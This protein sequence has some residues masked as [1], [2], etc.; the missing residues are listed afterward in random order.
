MMAQVILGDT[1]C[2]QFFR[3]HPWTEQDSDISVPNGLCVTY[4]GREGQFY[5]GNCLFSYSMNRTN[6][7]FSKLSSNPDLLN[8][9]LCGPYN[10]KGFLCGECVEGFGPAVY[11]ESLKCA[12]CSELPRGYAIGLYAV[13]RLVPLT[14][15]FILIAVFHVNITSGPLLG[16]MIFC[17]FVVFVVREKHFIIDF[18]LS[19]NHKFVKFLILL[20]LTLCEVWNLNFFRPFIPPFC[21]S[22]YLSTVHIKM[23]ELL[24]VIYILAL[25]LITYI[26]IEMYSH[27]K[28][29][30]ILCKPFRVILN[31]SNIYKVGWDSVVHA[32]ATVI[33]LS[34]T[35][36]IYVLSSLFH[37]AFTFSYSTNG[38]CEFDHN[39]L[40]IDPMVTYDSIHRWIYVCI[41]LIP[42]ILVVFIPS[43]L[44][45]LYPTRIYRDASRLIS[46]RKR[47][48]IT[49]F[50]E[51]LNSCFKDG[52]NGTID[53][54]AL[55][56]LVLILVPFQA[57]INV[58][59]WKTLFNNSFNR[60]L[61]LA[62][63]CFAS[64]LFVSSTRPCK[65]LLGNLSLS[66]HLMMMG[67][68]SLT[69]FL[70]EYDLSSSTQTLELVIFTI[71]II[72]HFLVLC[73]LINTIIKCLCW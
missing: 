61:I 35:S 72:S 29:V 41:A 12:N 14:L 33:L 42:C 51:T 68:L 3:S 5:A 21:I 58:L 8:K 4:S 7:M 2:P 38:T 56:G 64:S 43:I 18:T 32:F 55:A 23:L 52:L 47:L 70:W 25:S 17:Q 1:S 67:I 19:S 40:Y 34:S 63:I 73:W 48:A 39:I 31:K 66:Y 36:V 26:T 27:T 9:T 60:V 65:S 50:V 20:S 69:M 24:P 28:F 15:C 45:F 37:E 53:Y 10:R 54:R 11:S 16:Y 71:P 46:P 59:A 57:T 62:Y 49:V 30:K 13:L 6:R 22:E 44:L